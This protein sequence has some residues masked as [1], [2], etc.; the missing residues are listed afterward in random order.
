MLLGIIQGDP[1]S[2]LRLAPGWTPTL[3]DRAGKFSLTS[4][5][6]PV[7]VNEGC[8]GKRGSALEL[9][10]ALRRL[11][12]NQASQRPDGLEGAPSLPPKVARLTRE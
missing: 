4:I 10:R 8:A 11:I 2:Y 9:K 3:P 1:E 7:T 6:A 5:L 12:R